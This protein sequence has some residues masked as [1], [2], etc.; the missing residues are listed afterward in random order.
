MTGSEPQNKQDDLK[1]IKTKNFL[2]TTPPNKKE[3]VSDLLKWTYN[4][5]GD[6]YFKVITPN[7]S[8]HCSTPACSGMRFFEY[9]DAEIRVLPD[10]VK[11]V[12][13]LYVCRNCKLESKNFS[14]RIS[15]P[16]AENKTAPAQVFKYGE[17]PNFGPPVP[18]K[19]ITLFGSEKDYFIKGRRCENQGL[20]IAAFA[21]YRRVIEAKKNNIFDE[22]IRVSKALSAPDELIE[23][24]NK[25]KLET[26]FSKGVEAI[27]HAM[28]Q[29]L[30]I[31]GHNPL[32]LLH[33][34]LSEGLHN[35]T[36]EHCLELATDIR[37]V[38]TEFVEKLASALKED[39]EL[40]ASVA[41]LLKQKTKK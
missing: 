21:Y 19:L 32:Q 5:H 30:L 22:I 26:Q 36:D 39:S 1:V 23:E 31:N 16:S 13:L 33:S 20:G 24:L 27:K 4:S 28:P 37:N 3:I 40:S 8:L 35:Q 14:V 12:Y 7:I 41:R 9:I 34:P 17:I 38:L 15:T 11:D 2:E 18:T 10:R 25:A 6:D 29:S